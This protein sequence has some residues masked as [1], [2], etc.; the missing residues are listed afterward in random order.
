MES[1]D[2]SVTEDGRPKQILYDII[3]YR[4]WEQE[5]EVRLRNDIPIN[6]FVTILL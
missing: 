1:D 5:P 6:T 2:S 3:T 4:E